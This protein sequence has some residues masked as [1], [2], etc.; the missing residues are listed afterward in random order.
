VLRGLT[1][2]GKTLVLRRIERNQPGLTLD[3]EGLAGHRSS[4]LG[5]VGLEPCSQKMF[6]SRLCA[7]L[8]HGFPGA[9]IVEGESRKVGDVI[10][11]PALWE[12]MTDATNVL[13][14]A[15]VAHRVEVLCADYL[16]DERSRVELRA[17]L[18]H[19]ESRMQRAADATPLVELLDAGRTDELVKLLLEHYY[20]PLYRH[21]E[22][23]REHA[24]RVDASDPDR[25]AREIVDWA[26]SGARS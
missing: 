1:G 9:V 21:G 25:A 3:L 23:G 17:R 13:L 5:M 18:P 7:R 24:L 4:L 8:A 26:A 11:P 10:L 20:D 14:E 22:K 19:V 16:A 2:V 6:E 15:D 12:A